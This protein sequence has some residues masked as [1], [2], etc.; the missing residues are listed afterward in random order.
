L[1]SPLP[2][3]PGA[4][5]HIAPFVR[6]APRSQQRELL[7]LT[8]DLA[9]GRLSDSPTWISTS[10]TGVHWLHVRIENRPVYFTYHPYK[11]HRRDTDRIV[12]SH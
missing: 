5:A 11:E 10:G 9:L 12:V 4:N 1:V 2:I 6:G 7:A 8:A 3:A